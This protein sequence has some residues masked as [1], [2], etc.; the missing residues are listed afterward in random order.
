MSTFLRK[1]M[2]TFLRK[3]VLTVASM[4]FVSVLVS[5]A[6]AETIEA[7]Q[8]EGS[9]LVGS[10]QNSDH[11]RGAIKIEIAEM[12]DDPTDRYSQLESH[13]FLGTGIGM[14]AGGVIVDLLGGAGLLTVGGVIIGGA[15]GAWSAENIF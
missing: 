11:I 2:S 3:I 9:T 15:L 13:V 14:L 8:T 6:Y 12:L 7:S 4:L 5:P 1:T 10:G